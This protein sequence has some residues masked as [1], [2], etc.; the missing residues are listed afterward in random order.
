MNGHNKQKK[1]G[2]AVALGLYVSYPMIAVAQNADSDNGQIADQSNQSEAKTFDKV[3]V[4]ADRRDSFGRHG[5]N[6]A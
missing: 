2:I 3:S 6:E 1:L 4:T 5:F